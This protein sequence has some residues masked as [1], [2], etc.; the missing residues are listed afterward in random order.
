MFF[1]RDRAACYAAGNGWQAARIEEQLI[2]TKS[3]SE[4][5]TRFPAEQLLIAGRRYQTV[6]GPLPSTR[7]H[8]SN[9]NRQESPSAAE[10]I[11]LLPWL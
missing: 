3:G 7:E 6:T 11:P 9:L 10:K 8:Q 1:A 2:V 5:I 4:V